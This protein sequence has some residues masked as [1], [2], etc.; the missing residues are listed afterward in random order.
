[1]APAIFGAAGAVGKALAAEF[2]TAGAR[3]RVVGRSEGRLRRAFSAYD[4]LVEYCVAD[5]ED[6]QAAR[7]AAQGA[8]IIF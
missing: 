3:F 1:M 7:A 5:L 8:D 6:P 2:S 4:P